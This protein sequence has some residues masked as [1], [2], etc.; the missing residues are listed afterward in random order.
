M[1]TDFGDM[2]YAR[3][4]VMKFARQASAEDQ[5]S[6]YLLTNSKLYILH[7]FTSDSA[8][9]VRVLGGVKKDAN[10][11]DPDVAAADAANKRMNK[12]L[13]DAFAESNRFYKGRVIDR[14]GVTSEA[15]QDIARR[16]A[17]IPGRK[18]LIW[19]SS[20]FPIDIGYGRPI[21]A[22]GAGSRISTFET[23]SNTA[24]ALNNANVSVYPVDARGL[25]AEDVINMANGNN[26]GMLSG[27]APDS[28]PFT[29][30]NTIAA[31]T[32]GRAFYNGN[33]IAAS[34]RHA[35]EDSRESY[36]IGYYP[37][38]NK[39]D[40]TFRQIVV[41]VNRPGVT[42]RYRGGYFANSDATGTVAQRKQLLADAVRSPVQL[43]D[44]GLEIHAEPVDAPGGRQLSVQVRVNPDQMH[45]EQ[46]AD[47]FTDSLEIAWVELS[48]DGRI[49]ARGGH[50]LTLKPGQSGYDEIL[51]T[52]LSF[53]EH[54]GVKSEAVEMRLVVRDD[55]SGA[56]GS[57]NIPLAKLL[58]Q[59]GASAP[60]KK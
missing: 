27:A 46:S 2:S 39:W 30:M 42:L 54:V 22:R 24:K 36:A 26:R 7:D 55:G 60:V 15:M 47:R 5:I 37:D 48:A 23:L 9:L 44:L 21:G 40:G 53:S 25:I 6:L 38:H 34:I 8:T 1:N 11:S 17:A 50:T 57:V 16:V 52:G 56:A 59:S 43:I 10:N 51:K 18:N 20:G 4:Q 14:A 45:F 49:L 32:G 33:D 19:V 31:G 35:I 28:R 29:T 41:K 58:T 3:A 13:S 12:A